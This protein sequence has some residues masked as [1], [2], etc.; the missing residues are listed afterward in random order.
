[1]NSWTNRASGRGGELGN[2]SCL[3]DRNKRPGGR[4]GRAVGEKE[5]ENDR[6]SVGLTN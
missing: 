3:G 2:L 6:A 5:G 4:P 1:L